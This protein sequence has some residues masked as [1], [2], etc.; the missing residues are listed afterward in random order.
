MSP[1]NRYLDAQKPF[2]RKVRASL[3]PP[4]VY[5]IADEHGRRERENGVYRGVLRPRRQTG[6]CGV[7]QERPSGGRPLFVKGRLSGQL[8]LAASAGRFRMYTAMEEPLAISRTDFRR[9][10]PWP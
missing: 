3:M 2:S 6:S 8:R 7:S 9:E 4:G 1:K 10:T 5:N